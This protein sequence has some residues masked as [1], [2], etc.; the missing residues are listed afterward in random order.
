MKPSISPEHFA[1]FQS[2]INKTILDFFSPQQSSTQSTPPPPQ[3]ITQQQ[4]KKK[5][6]NEKTRLQYKRRSLQTVQEVKHQ[7]VEHQELGHS[8]VQSSDQAIKH[9]VLK[10]VARW[11][12]VA[13]W[14]AVIQH[15]MTL[16]ATAIDVYGTAEM[17]RHGIG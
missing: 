4:K 17:S 14:Y 3:P 12:A 5:K 15:E 11:L 7:E 13:C 6:R 2:T 10:A 16:D 9:V 1:I 8:G